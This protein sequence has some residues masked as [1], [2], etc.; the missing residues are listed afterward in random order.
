MHLETLFCKYGTSSASASYR[1][2][3]DVSF[4][5]QN[6]NV[7]LYSFLNIFVSFYLNLVVS[8]S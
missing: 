6:Y 4:W 5:I 1:L 8:N 7:F 2:I 3:I